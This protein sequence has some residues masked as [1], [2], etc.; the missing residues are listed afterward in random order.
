M[1][2]QPLLG[3]EEFNPHPLPSEEPP[4]LGREE[5][6]PNPTDF[7]I[8]ERG[9]RPHPHMRH[10]GQP[11]DDG[12]PNHGHRFRVIRV[13]FCVV[14]WSIVAIV[15]IKLICCCCK[16]GCKKKAN[17]AQNLD[18][19][20][21]FHYN[22]ARR[23]EQIKNSHLVQNRPTQQPVYPVRQ[24]QM[25]YYEPEVVRCAPRQHIQQRE[26]REVPEQQIPVGRPVQSNNSSFAS[27]YPSI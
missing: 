25:G 27:E 20:I 14:F 11:R 2:E 8:D 12:V 24:P 5:F 19:K 9:M 21:Q 10:D 7:E 26:Y 1:E 15:M 6:N 17:R 23:L 13:I 16:S 4:I 18:Q 22:E 3:R